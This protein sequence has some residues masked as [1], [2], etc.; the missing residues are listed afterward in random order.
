MKI[1]GIIRDANMVAVKSKFEN[2]SMFSALSA[3]Q[4]NQCGVYRGPQDEDKILI[5]S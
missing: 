2:I 4:E 1:E 3:Q 5:T